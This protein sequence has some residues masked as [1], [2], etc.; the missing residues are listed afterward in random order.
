MPNNFNS[1]A[2]DVIAQEALTRL[3]QKL[4]FVKKINTNYSSTSLSFG[5]SV[6]THI[7]TEMTAQDW[8][9]SYI[10][11]KEDAVQ[12]DVLVPLNTHK[13]VTFQLTD[14]ERDSSDIELFSRFAEVASYALAKGIVDHLI[15]ASTLGAN[16]GN[17]DTATN[18]I[19]LATGGL[20]MD[21]LID[22][23]AK[24][25][26]AGIPESQRWL[27]GHPSVLAELEKEVTAVT[28]AT[29]NV[30]NSIVEG[31]VNRIRGFNIYS[32]NGGVLSATNTNIGAVAGFGDSLALVTAPPSSPPD[33]AGASLAYITDPSTGLTIQRRQWYD[34]NTGVYAFALTLYLGAVLTA[35]DRMFKIKN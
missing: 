27:V 7:L 9:T 23:G 26:S 15:G 18:Q 35:G 16:A 25:D 33:S 30:S 12:N 6:N 14:A 24:F 1:V 3:I 28:N 13:H 22:L 11:N 2:V 32:Y 21:H 31:G 17:I 19:D 20:T 8:T 29:F 5:S 10:N 34:A 4:D